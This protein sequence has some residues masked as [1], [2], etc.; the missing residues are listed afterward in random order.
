MEKKEKQRKL[1]VCTKTFWL[2]SI[3]LLDHRDN[4][5]RSEIRGLQRN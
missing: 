1:E 5:A 4:N 3:D 2:F